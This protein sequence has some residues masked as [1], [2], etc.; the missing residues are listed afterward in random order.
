MTLAVKVQ[1]QAGIFLVDLVSLAAIVQ[2]AVLTLTL[3][4]FIFQFRS[5]E[6]AIKESAYQELIGRYN[7]YSLSGQAIDE[8][9]L[10]R[11]FSPGRKLSN[12]E[13][14]SIQRLMGAYSLIEEAYELYEK[15]WIDKEAWAQ[16]DAW[17]KAISKHPQFSTLHTRMSGMFDK[18]FQDYITQML[19]SNQVA[20]KQDE[21]GV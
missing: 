17:L 19:D 12:E 6:R 21:S 3:I 18:E 5:Q 13:L 7:E 11:L 2:T 10:E 16:W 9:L 8:V 14:A 1:A 20:A 15:G 4:V